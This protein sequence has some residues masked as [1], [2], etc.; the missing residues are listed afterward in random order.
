M[1]APLISDCVTDDLEGLV[2][3]LYVTLSTNNNCHLIIYTV[4]EL[5]M[6]IDHVKLLYY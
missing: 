5:N 2:P 1:E 4:Y 3:K 6:S